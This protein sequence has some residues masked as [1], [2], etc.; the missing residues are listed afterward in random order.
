MLNTLSAQLSYSP[1]ECI[2]SYKK[3]FNDIINT[4]I[5]KLNAKIEKTRKIQM[6][7]KRDIELIERLM[8]VSED[9]TSTEE[10][11]MSIARYP[12][13][14][15]IVTFDVNNK[16]INYN[17]N[18]VKLLESFNYSKKIKDSIIGKNINEV[19]IHDIEL[20]NK[21]P[22]INDVVFETKNVYYY[23]ILYCSID[24][25]CYLC[26]TSLVKPVYVCPYFIRSYSEIE[27]DLFECIQCC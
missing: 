20:N 4:K 5:Y 18:F 27:K 13:I 11:M 2:D 16:I 17:K 3:S 24:N 12:D 8:A 19:I 10:V 6:I 26:T 14:D 25:I 23:P 9:P 22:E 21:Q 7:R 15:K 1:F